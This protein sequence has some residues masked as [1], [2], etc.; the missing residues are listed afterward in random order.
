MA[1]YEGDGS[2]DRATVPVIE[3]M[4]RTICV[5]VH[6]TWRNIGG[7]GERISLKPPVRQICQA[8]TPQ[9]SIDFIEHPYV[10]ITFTIEYSARVP[11]DKAAYKDVK[12]VKHVVAWE[13]YLPELDSTGHVKEQ[14]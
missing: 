5:N 1:I 8:S 10:A 13:T 7:G 3:I 9:T 6:N 12:H 14:E 2:K 4:E 11:V